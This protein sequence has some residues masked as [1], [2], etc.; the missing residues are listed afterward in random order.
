M[1]MICILSVCLSQSVSILSMYVEASPILSMEAAGGWRYMSQA[2]QLRNRACGTRLAQTSVRHAAI[3]NW[4]RLAATSALE[5][6]CTDVD[7]V[8]RSLS[9]HRALRDRAA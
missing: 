9:L 1:G 7:V 2:S 6:S 4:Q 3:V 5:E 8:R